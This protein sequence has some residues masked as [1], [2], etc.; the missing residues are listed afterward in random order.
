[1]EG[2]AHPELLRCGAELGMRRWGDGESLPSQ[3][4]AEAIVPARPHHFSQPPPGL[5]VLPGVI[6]LSQ[7]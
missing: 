5:V 4:G 1:M 3:C 2:L 7:L 6:C